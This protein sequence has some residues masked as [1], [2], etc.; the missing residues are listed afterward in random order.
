MNVLAGIVPI[1]ILFIAIP[2]FAIILI[3]NFVKRAEKRAEERLQ[4]E[5]ENL[6]LLKNQVSRLEQLQKKIVQ[7]EQMLTNVE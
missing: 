5:R 7:I 2:I 1:L 3:Y 6:D 4:I